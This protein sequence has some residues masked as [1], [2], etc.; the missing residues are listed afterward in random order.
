MD[1]SN[2]EPLLFGTDDHEAFYIVNAL[3]TAGWI[4]ARIAQGWQAD[5]VV[6]PGG[7]SH[8]AEMQS[9][10][11]RSSTNPAFVAMWFGDDKEEE[12]V[13]FMTELFERHIC[14]AIREAGYKAERVDLVP[15]N[16][17]VMDKVLGMIRIASLL[18]ADFTGN[19]AG[20]YF[21]AGYGRGLG[22]PVIHTCRKSHFKGA[23]FDIQQ[24][25]TIVWSTPEDL[26][27]KLHH[28]IVGTLGPGP[29]L[30]KSSG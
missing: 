28:R 26:A 11:A 13:A 8:I 24:I 17:F 27:E 1:A 19:R 22:I 30:S 20:V 3:Q 18:V 12:T 9:R 4:E 2:R 10:H 29:Y 25:N 6:T 15:H 5:V 16:D 14:P 21:E 23:H 7:W